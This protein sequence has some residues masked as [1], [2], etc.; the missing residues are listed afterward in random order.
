[1]SKSRGSK[2]TLSSPIGLQRK[3]KSFGIRR[4]NGPNPINLGILRENGPN[5]INLATISESEMN[6]TRENAHGGKEPSKTGNS[7]SAVEN[8]QPHGLKPVDESGI[9]SSG[10]SVLSFSLPTNQEIRDDE[11]E[12]EVVFDFEANENIRS[13][14]SLEKSVEQPTKQDLSLSLSP[15]ETP[16]SSSG[17]GEAVK[18]F[19]FSQREESNSRFKLGEDD[20]VSALTTDTKRNSRLKHGRK[21][22]KGIFRKKKR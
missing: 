7:P 19:S 3:K 16:Q 20:A 12:V 2:S 15:P 8:P 13:P 10:Q 14:R 4:K 17:A 1:M 22:M 5:S 21:T 11:D 9:T 6:E 18:H